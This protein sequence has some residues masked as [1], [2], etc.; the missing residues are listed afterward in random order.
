MHVGVKIIRL[1]YNTGSVFFQKL[2]LFK[3]KAKRHKPKALKVLR[4]KHNKSVRKT[5]AKPLSVRKHPWNAA[6]GC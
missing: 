5:F 6:S 4:K 2:L 1:N 3:Y